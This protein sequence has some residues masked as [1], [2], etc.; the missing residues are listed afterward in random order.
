MTVS[1][2]VPLASVAVTFRRASPND[3]RSISTV[4]RR[5]GTPPRG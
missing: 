5:V 2:L 1:A 3:A 4:V